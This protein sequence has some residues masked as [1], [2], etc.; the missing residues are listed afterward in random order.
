MSDRDAF[1]DEM[2]F[3]RRPERDPDLAEFAGAVQAALVPSQAPGS[4]LI[5]PRL[6]E[7]ARAT[8][9]TVTAPAAIR[10]PAPRRRLGLAVRIA[11]V[12]ALLPLFS[13]GLAVAGVKLPGPAQSVFESVGIDLPNQADEP[14][15]APDRGGAAGAGGAGER[16]DDASG[17]PAAEPGAHGR[18]NAMT[19]RGHGR[20]KS[21]P[22]R[23]EGGGNGAHGQGEP[24]NSGQA[25]GHTRP[26]PPQSNGKAIGKTDGTP[27]G[28]A[29]KPL[30]PAKPSLPAASNG[31]RG[32]GAQGEPKAKGK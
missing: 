19:E 28:Q 16:A 6:A 14:A 23:E 18:E 25:P 2:G 9:P 1:E 17:A 8:A 15:E 24:G 13:A 26:L 32:G 11:F 20:E 5:V 12:V 7:A 29:K 22:A 27:P 4:E 31:S 10:T 30:K 21:D 3:L